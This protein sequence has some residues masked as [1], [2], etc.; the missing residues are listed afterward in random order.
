MKGIGE[1]WV[2]MR[3]RL[4]IQP[5]SPLNPTKVGFIFTRPNS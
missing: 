5:Y 4:N 1:F 3:T 2:I